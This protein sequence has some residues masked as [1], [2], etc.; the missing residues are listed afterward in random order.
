VRKRKRKRK[1]RGEEWREEG[2]RKGA[3]RVMDASW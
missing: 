1:G 3:M 2:G